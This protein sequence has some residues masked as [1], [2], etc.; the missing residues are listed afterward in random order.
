MEEMIPV[1]VLITAPHG[2]MRSSLNSYL[3]TLENVYL[4]PLLET[5][6][7]TVLFIKLIRTDILIVDNE[8]LKNGGPASAAAWL[9]EVGKINPRLKIIMLVEDSRGIQQAVDQGVYAAFV[10]GSIHNHLKDT[11]ISSVSL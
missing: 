1:H 5:L 3:L 11:I 10:K 9:R 7:D 4:H 6:A 2:T 8:L